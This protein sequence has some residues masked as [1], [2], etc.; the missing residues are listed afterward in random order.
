[1]VKRFISG[2]DSGQIIIIAALLVPVLL[3]MTALAVDLGSYAGDR[4][5][6]QNAADAIALA[7]ADDLCTPN[8]AICTDTT[9]ASTTAIAYATKNGIS[10]GD[11][12]VTFTGLTGPYNASNPAPTARA[13]IRRPHTFAF[14]R[15]LGIT[16]RSVGASAA[17]VKTS[18]GGLA[19][20]TPW[21]VTALPAPG[22]SVVLKFD[23]SGGCQST[24]PGN[25]GAMQF[26]FNQGSGAANY[27]N[28]IA[29]GSTST[30]CAQGVTTCTNTSPVCPTYD[31]CPPQTGNILGPTRNGVDFL[32]AN[33][34]ASCNTF[35]QAFAGPDAYGKYT[36]NPD[37]NPWTAGPGGC[38]RPDPNPPPL[39]SR[40]VIIIPVVN[41]FGN[42]NA[43]VTIVSFA[44]FWL[45]GFGPGGCT[46]GNSCE[47]QGTYVK[48]DMTVNALAGIY[49]PNS[50]MHFTRLTE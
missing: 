48:A 39:C 19:G 13:S 5:K 22:T 16:S 4:R 2:R 18:P 9:T 14:I 17:A 15:V 31:T 26:D 8:P 45:D 27:T 40:R 50:S 38:P 23:S 41:G 47:I 25:C 11:L 49:D 32:V 37:C 21:A 10:P 28:T 3:G 33:T 44:L 20:L 43:S 30:I 34:I 1:M 6:L 35:A 12:T 36:L 7:A 42:G 24:G 46:Q 29:H